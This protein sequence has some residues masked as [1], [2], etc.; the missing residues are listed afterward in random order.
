MSDQDRAEAQREAG[1]A[2]A[3]LEQ[4]LLDL[5]LLPARV[6]RAPIAGLIERSA[7]ALDALART[8]ADP[9]A[10]LEHLAVA[11][12]SADAARALLA[13]AGAGEA[14]TPSIERLEAVRRSLGAYES[15]L[16]ERPLAAPARAPAEGPPAAV[17]LRASVG[18]PSLHRLDRPPLA[19]P[20]PRAALDDEDEDDD[21][22]EVRAP[23]EGGPSAP[24]L[25]QLRRLARD[26]L[27]EIGALGGLRGAEGDTPWSPALGRFEQRMLDDLD[28][29]AS[30]SLASPIEGETDLRLDVAREALAYAEDAFVADPVRPFARAFVLGCIAGEDAARA[31][32]VA[33]RQSHP[34]THDAQRSALSLA[35]SPAVDEAMRALAQ[36]DDPALVR[37]AL[38]VLRARG[39]AT[40]D[41]AVVLV[42][43]PDPGV[44]R[45]AAACLGPAPASPALLGRMIDDDADDEVAAAAAESLLIL[46]LGEGIA[47]LRRRLEG[48]AHH[49]L[50][51]LLAVAGGAHDAGRLAERLERSPDAAEA[52]GWHGHPGHVER[53]IEALGRSLDEPGQGPFHRATAAALRRITG[54]SV[55][56]D[57]GG[58]AAIRAFWGEHRARFEP[59]AAS[60]RRHRLGRPYTP[61]ASLDELGAEGVPGRDRETLALEVAIA[62]RGAS[63][64]HVNGWVAAQREE[65]ARLRELCAKL[66]PPSPG[67]FWA[68]H[69]R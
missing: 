56:P 22:M 48:S 19:A 18:R 68:P 13:I 4:A 41:L 61:A 7:A 38:D 62:S 53:L 44:R 36:H 28:A 57:R 3:L 69:R 54:V 55:H 50:F 46:D 37:L 23:D 35:S 30:L 26:A 10:H 60:P 66:D 8:D 51:R 64:L 67:A 17:P 63:R 40:F 49:G 20:I 12:A 65:I 45:R 43:H 47:A 34:D 5:A 42:G 24:W 58:L 9:A 27:E 2:L 32:V 33:L 39:T 1:A 16:L 31:A 25:V 14:G 29:L 21:P 59:D 52:L 15:R 11:R 6:A